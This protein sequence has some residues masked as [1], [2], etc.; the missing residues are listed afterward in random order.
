[1]LLLGAYEQHGPHLPLDTDTQIIEAITM[2]SLALVDAGH[3]L[4]APTIPISASDEHASF[5][6]T[7]SAGT[8]A[9]AAAIVAIRRSAWWARGM[10]IVNGHGGNSDAIR[11]A[12]AAM[13]HEGLTHSVWSP[14]SL[15]RG[16]MHAGHVETSIMLHL[17]PSRVR[18]EHME[19]GATVRDPAELLEMMRAGGVAAVSENG[20]VGDP[21]MATAEDGRR[22]LDA[23]V[24]SLVQ[25]LSESITKWPPHDG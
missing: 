13:D 20:V 19:D 25:F 18:R 9:V 4:V 7:L 23:Y 2:K 17:D 22:F 16:D 10:C 21:R 14:P 3:F 1:M 8:E 24:A 12:V 15:L 11:R 6:G 5:A